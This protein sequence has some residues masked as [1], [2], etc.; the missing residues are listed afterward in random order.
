MNQP[1]IIRTV[2]GDIPSSDL[3]ICYPHEHVFGAPPKHL[4]STDFELTSYDAALKE[5]GWFYEAGGRALVDMST[6]DYNR[7]VHG[8]G[9]ISEATGVHIIAATGFNKDR[10]SKPLIEDQTDAQLDQ[11]LIN[12]VTAGIENTGLKAG[13]LKA[14]S[15]LNTI[16][17]TA[18]RVFKSVARVHLLTRVP[19]STH[20]EAG[21][22]APEQVEL[23]ANLGVLPENII[24]GHLDRKLDWPYIRDVA[25]TGVF[26][27]FDQISKEKY[28][29]DQ[30]RINMILKL[31]AQGHGEQILLSGDL[32]RRS[33]WPS[34]NTGGG[35]GFTFILWRF[36]PWLRE[37][38]VA[39]H[40]IEDLIVNNPARAL[41]FE[42]V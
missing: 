17:S 22:M 30:L 37:A 12:D 19:I 24:I 10:F 21:T 26:L 32:A 35:P 11:L 27:G 40:Q 13:V 6:L 14:A 41:S 16:S 38:G 7:D 20:T 28:Y 39:D 31:I 36:V 29:P 25:Q 1:R 33:Y 9:K 4:T 23:L 15:T 5:I 34:Y 18:E 3:G 2:L 8:L 42:P